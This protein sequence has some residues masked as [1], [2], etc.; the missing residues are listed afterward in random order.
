MAT[1]TLRPNATDFASN[2][3]NVVGATSV[4]AAL[5][6]DSDASYVELPWGALVEVTLADLTMPSGAL[7]KQVRSRLRARRIGTTDTSVFLT[8][9]GTGTEHQWKPSV[10]TSIANHTGPWRTV[11]PSGGAWTDSVVDALL[12]RIYQGNDATLEAYE[13]YVDVEYN[14]QPVGTLTAP[15]GTYTNDSSPDAVWSYSDP[16]SDPQTHYRLVIEPGDTSANAAPALDGT[17]EYDSGETSGSGTSATLPGLANGTYTVWLRVRQA[18]VSGQTQRSE[19]D[20]IVYTINVAPPAVPTIT[21]NADDPH[22]RII[23]EADSS[24][25]AGEEAEE[26]DFQFSDNGTTWTAVRTGTAVPP[27]SATADDPATVYDYESPPNT[28]RFYRARAARY[29]SGSGER[30]VSSWSTSVQAALIP[31]RWWLK[32]PDSPNLNAHFWVQNYT[33]GGDRLDL[34]YI[35]LDE[36]EWDAWRDLWNT[37]STLLL[38]NRETKQWYVR[39]VGDRAAVHTPLGRQYPVVVDDGTDP[40]PQATRIRGNQARRLQV[41][42]IIQPR[43]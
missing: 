27:D 14:E 32:A 24:S 5:S 2:N 34:S 25:T 22:G 9:G 37:N 38:Q 41:T 40:H 13:A 20:A 35:L 19:W 33:E 3:S 12:Q 39:L 11:K 17:E 18:D 15:T 8:E 10:T 42:A 6:D 21:A 31:I 29:D 28:A 23:L 26:Y 1:V 30:L 4:H 36:D 43:P 16:E 7:I